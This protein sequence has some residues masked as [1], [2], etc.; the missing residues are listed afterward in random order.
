MSYSRLMHALQVAGVQLDRKTLADIAVRDP[1]A[2]GQVV[3]A[4]R[5]A[6]A[7]V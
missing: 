4:A 6:V 7:S 5:Q 1:A 2:F 3:E